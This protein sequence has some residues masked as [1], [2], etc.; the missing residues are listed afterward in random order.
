MDKVDSA[1]SVLELQEAQT[2]SP[3][4]WDGRSNEQRTIPSLWRP[5]AS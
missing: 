2:N 5:V 3:F 4:Q 1:D